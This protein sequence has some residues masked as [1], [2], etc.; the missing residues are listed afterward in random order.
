MTQSAYKL[1]N[2][3]CEKVYDIQADLETL[4][5]W[6]SEYKV[7]SDSKD[8]LTFI[9]ERFTEVSDKL[10]EVNSDDF[11]FL[12]NLK[13][14]ELIG[15]CSQMTST[16]KNSLSKLGHGETTKLRKDV[17]KEKQTLLDI[18]DGAWTYYS[19]VIDRIHEV[20]SPTELSTLLY[21]YRDDES[22]IEWIIDH[23]VDLS[24]MTPT[25]APTVQQT[26]SREP[27]PETAAEENNA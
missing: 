4:Y 19:F 12:D 13:K 6:F 11:M 8:E 9:R 14:Y 17:E 1:R 2:E 3:I 16:V 15:K 25:E 27:V 26:R 23:Y 5:D 24:K 18:I 21:G 20:S 10:G 7:D 22:R